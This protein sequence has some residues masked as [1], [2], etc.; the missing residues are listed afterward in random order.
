MLA[1]SILCGLAFMGLKAVEYADHFKHGL[2]PG[3]YLSAHEIKQ[4]GV[5]KQQ[6]RLADQVERHVGH[7]D[8]FFQHRAVAGPFAQAL[9]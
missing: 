6:A 8:V 9:A 7:R 3:K 1:I 2:L 5:A 4:P